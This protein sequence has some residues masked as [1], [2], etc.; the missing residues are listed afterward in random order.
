MSRLTWVPH[1]ANQVFAYG[2][3][4]RSGASFQTLLLTFM[5]LP[6]TRN[7]HDTFVLWVWAVFSRFARRYFGNHSLFSFPQGTEMFHFPWFALLAL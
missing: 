5:V 3:I 4:T 6:W 7:P 2:A 1:S